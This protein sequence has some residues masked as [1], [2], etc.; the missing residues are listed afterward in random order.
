[1]LDA[2]DDFCD[3]VKSANKE[4]VIYTEKHKSSS[5]EAYFQKRYKKKYTYDWQKDALNYHA[6]VKSQVLKDREKNA[7]ILPAKTLGKKASIDSSESV[8][9]AFQAEIGVMDDGRSLM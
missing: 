7:K 3:F 4:A 6:S 2:V 1:M 9:R 8:T 5:S